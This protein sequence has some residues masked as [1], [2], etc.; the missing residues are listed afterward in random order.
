MAEKQKSNG[1]PGSVKEARGEI[2]L[3]R[4]PDGGPQIDVRLEQ[5]SIWLAQAQIAELFQRDRSVITKHM[6]N[7]F[8]EGEL[9]KKSNV[10]KM[11]IPHSDKPILFYNL[12]V[13]LSVGYRVNSMQETDNAE[14]IDKI[15]RRTA[16][17]SVNAAV[18]C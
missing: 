2:I 13:I 1:E 11:H 5:E 7:I 16:W 15:K 12:D 6:N 4:T 10:Q 3:Y 14:K 8:R 9:D 17:N 18:I